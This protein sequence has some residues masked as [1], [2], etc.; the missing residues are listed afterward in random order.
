MGQM[1][2]IH[3]PTP[4]IFTSHL[5]F[6]F[7]SKPNSTERI[8]SWEALSLSANEEIPRL[9]SIPNIHCYLNSLTN[10]RI[11]N[12]TTAFKYRLCSSAVGT[13]TRYGLDGPVIESQWGARFSVLIQTGRGAHP[14]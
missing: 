5:K 2:P 4:H 14:A 10:A 8:S 6:I 3:I 7:I 9:L 11:Q 13:A 12:I 1:S